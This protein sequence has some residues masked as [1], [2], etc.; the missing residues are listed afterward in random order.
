MKIAALLA[1][2]GA[3]AALPTSEVPKQESALR[4]QFAAWKSNFQK[5]YETSERELLAMAAFTEN[6]AIIEEHNAK[7]LSWTLGHNEWSDMTWSTFQATVMGEIFLNRNP[8]N[9]R[10]EFIQIEGGPKVA[11]S[12]DWVTKGGVTPV[13]NQA[14]CGS[15]WAFSTTGAVEGAYFVANQT[16][17]SLSEENLVECDTVDSG[18]KGGLMDN[19]FEFIEKNGVCAESAYP[20][21]SGGGVRGSCKKTCTP[22]VT[23]TGFKD[24]PQKNEIALKA[25]VAQQPV[26]IAIE[27]DKSA[28]QLYK[29]GVL[30]STTCGTQ[31][32]H[33][34]LLVGYGTDSGKD[35]WKVKNSWGA[36]WGEGGY[37]RMA[38]GKN[39]CGVAQQPSYPKGAHAA[40][41]APGPTPPGPSPSDSHYEDPS[42]GCKTD[43]VE[44]SIQG[45]SGDF[46]SPK[47]SSFFHHCPSDVPSGVTATPQCALQS[48]GSST[49]YCAL[50]CSPTET[51]SDQAVADAQCGTN[52]SCKPISGVGICTYND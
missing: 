3:A 9:A 4:V 36:T 48:S 24:V 6:D 43:E 19:A 5:A 28:F 32:D 52:A 35:Y 39:M 27:A 40:G 31:L 14:Q 30:D 42:A 17:I 50:I 34:V 7:G 49:K 47:C 45:V 46:C 18:C 26:S 22:V 16:L 2:F 29:S 37:I 10:R 1:I 51:I 21:T 20:Y 44:L 23:L 33:G 15:C 25:A 41:P 12:T 11:D 13:K 8:K 38:R